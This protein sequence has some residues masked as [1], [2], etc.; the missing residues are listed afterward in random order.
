[1]KASLSANELRLL[2]QISTGQGLKSVKLANRAWC[3]LHREATLKDLSNTGLSEERILALRDRI[4]EMGLV[5]LIDAPRPGR[6]P[7]EVNGVR[8]AMSEGASTRAERERIWRMARTMPTSHVPTRERQVAVAVRAIDLKG[9]PVVPVA[10]WLGATFQAVATVSKVEA[11]IALGA[12][13]QPSAAAKRGFLSHAKSSK[14][15]NEL[16]D[17]YEA[18]AAASPKFKP[19]SERELLKYWCNQLAKLAPSLGC[20]LHVCAPHPSEPLIIFL[21]ELR[22]NSL[23]VGVNGLLERLDFYDAAGFEMSLKQLPKLPLRQK[24]DPHASFVWT[25]FSVSKKSEVDLSH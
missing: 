24:L 20:D 12:W 3:L 18:H 6:P 4:S 8:K 19:R 1:M 23:W 25:A 17:A 11:G 22:R 9:S 13:H 10:C 21:S 7:Q 15:S 16:F 2:S 5:G 14:S